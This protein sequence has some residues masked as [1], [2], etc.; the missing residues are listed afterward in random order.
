MRKSIDASR[1]HSKAFVVCAS[2]L[3]LVCCLGRASAEDPWPW[4][5]TSEDAVTLLL[6]GDFNVQKR[7][8][9]ADA[10]RHVVRTLN[11]ADLVY[12]NLEGLLVESRGP[13]HD[14]PNKSGWTHLGP[15]SVAALVAG[16]ISVVGVANNVAYGRENILESLSV[17]DAHG[18]AH[19]GAGEDLDAAHEPAIVE[20]KGV[21][22]GFL[23]Y[24]SKWYDES[25]Q[26]ATPDAAGVARLKSMDGE[27]IDS[28]DL[29]RMLDDIRELRPKV[30]ILV[31]SAHTR[32]GQGRS[33]AGGSASPHPA[34][35]PEPDLY[36]RLPVNENLQHYEPYQ[37]ALAR[38]AID[39]GADIVFGH[40][41]HMLQAVETYRGK[42]VMHCLGNSASDWIRVRDYRDGLVA[43]VVVEDRSVERVSL[44]PLTRG[45]DND[46]RLVA[47]GSAEGERL[48]KRLKE[49]S[50]DTPLLLE[51]QELVLI[52][53][54]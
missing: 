8:D 49:L 35:A 25:E 31:V 22:F 5:D 44:V 1:R 29:E 43:R 40:G 47:P 23:Q 10:L 45:E 20:A 7:D 26:I 33:G 37:A 11:R 6:L 38:A 53:E 4:S 52:D 2:I 12:A 24:T 48:H 13:A 18:I 21:T 27:T 36:S 39:A 42:P 41:C 14:L 9:P 46:V 50:R 28:G 16:N 17:L 19:T 3:G 15:E 54:R 30:D 34:S 32:D 51:G